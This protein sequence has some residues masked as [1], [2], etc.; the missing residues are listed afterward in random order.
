MILHR[1][2]LRIWRRDPGAPAL[3][4]AASGRIWTR[5][6][7]EQAARR[8]PPAA[9][10]AVSGRALFF[11][12]PNGL[13]WWAAF[14]SALRTGRV[15]APVDPSEPPAA[16]RAIAARAARRLPPEAELLKLTSG[17]T[18]RPRAFPFTGRQMLADGR[19][20]AATMGITAA[21]THLGLVPLGH[22]YGLGNLVIPLLRAGTPIICG[23]APLP[24]AVAAAARRGATV[25]PAVP[26]L[27][28]ALA[29][30]GIPS[31]GLGPL[32]LVISAGAPLDAE[33]AVRFHQRFGLRVHNFYGSSE[34]GG[35]AY[36]RSGEATLAGRSVGRPLR[37]VR[38]R[39]SAAG[40]FTVASAA[41]MGRGEHTPADRG[42]PGPKG[43]LV[44]LGRL[45]RAL[46]I[47]GRRLDPAEIEAAVRRIA[48]VLECCVLAHP[49]RPEALAAVVSGRAA[50]T[51]QQLDAALRPQL[52]PWKIP[53]K[54]A[55]APAL[56]V[57]A[58]GKVDRAA[59]AA[60]LQ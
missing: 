35:I 14:L 42:R 12:A 57:N 49:R 6:D 48:G 7:L 58:R 9:A 4:D 59:V 18:G 41:V 31:G 10:V 27:L 38:L 37:G 43:E 32:R 1:A 54:W 29:E 51:P 55:F 17:S 11:S 20:I 16:A 56:P 5:D 26:A 39:Y 21:D 44:L 60:L 33:T 15:A 53:R 50:L 36:D 3:I 40:R 13:E 30:S 25:F 24:H 8:W 52:A 22:S 23:V 2:W 19:H 47:A 45:G 46:K 34:T 28:R